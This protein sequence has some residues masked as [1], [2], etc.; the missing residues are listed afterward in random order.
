M[1]P[2]LEQIFNTEL[3]Q[4]LAQ[5]KELLRFPS[6]SMEAEHKDNCKGCAKWLDSHLRAIGFSS[7]IINTS[8]HPVVFALKEGD[9]AAPV[10]LYYG[11][12]DVQ[13]VDPVEAWDS[14]PFEPELRNNRMYARGAQD[15]KG[16][17]FYSI[18]ALEAV[19]KAGSCKPTIKILIEGDEESGSKG[20]AGVLP[21]LKNRLNADLLLVTDTG[22]VSSGAPTIVMGLRGIAHMSIE[23]H[24]PGHDLHSGAHGG[25]A[26]N[27][28][29]EICRL[30]ASLH[31]E[32][33]RI[34]VKGFYDNVIEASEKEQLLADAGF[35]ESSYEKEVG[36]RPLAGEKNYTP[37]QRIGL[38][39]C[40]DVNGVY[41]GY[42]GSGIKT[43]IPAS[44]KA[45]ISTRLVP[46]QD[47]KICVQLIIDHLK[48]HTPEGMKLTISDPMSIG[49]ALR[50][51]PDSEYVKKTAS[52]LEHITGKKIAYQWDGASIP[53]VADLA[54]A[55]GAV[56]LLV[57]F[58][59][60][61]DNIHAP[62]E[63]FA[64]D[65]FKHGFMYVASLIMSFD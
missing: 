1:K 7:E 24:G 14:P 21:E 46:C 39:P 59:S 52:I 37:A 32:N 5:W 16:Q 25:G 49:G 51:G 57:G 62:N 30:L 60:Q 8:S 11:H 45:K 17:I 53:I 42:S 33:G 43:V 47:P 65:R 63:S 61:E 55:S 26:R 54:N 50:I 4:F 6:I 22:T 41:A 12:Y 23:L 58:G 64:L 20:I 38:R 35:D 13:P 18:K 2:D 19:I 10:I 28:A 31:E 29:T 56:P 9:E 34:A 27:P 3:D 44:A 48:S 36:M 15:N 40:I